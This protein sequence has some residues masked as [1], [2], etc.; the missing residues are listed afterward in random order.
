VLRS[1]PKG[2]G[3]FLGDLSNQAGVLFWH[4]TS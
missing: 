4:E 1:V 3:L 2:K